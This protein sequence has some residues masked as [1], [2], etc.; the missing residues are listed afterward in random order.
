[1]NQDNPSA[2]APETKPDERALRFTVYMIRHAQPTTFRDEDGVRYDIPPGPSLAPAGREQAAMAA[3]FIRA[4]PPEI[5][6]TSPLNRALQTAQII[7]Q[8][9]QAPLAIDERLAE[10]RREETNDQLAAR[11]TQFWADRISIAPGRI[12][13]VSHGAP[14]RAMLVA[15]GDVLTADPARYR[16][17]HGNIAPPAGIWRARCLATGRTCQWDLALIFRTFLPGD[18]WSN[19]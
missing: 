19:T 15:L 12:G 17:D 9:L 5:I 14:I 4:L 16:F 11:L 7:A 2:P 18:A 1:M 8:R 6:Y 10:R 13:L 3:D